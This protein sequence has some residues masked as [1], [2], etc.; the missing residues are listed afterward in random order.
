VIVGAGVVGLACGAALARAG[1]EVLVLE[2]ADRIG[3]Q[4]S[5]R[6][7]EVIHAGIYYPSGSLKAELCR[8]GKAQLY[9]YAKERGIPHRQT[10]KMIVATS[11]DQVSH[12]ERIAGNA[13]ANNVTDLRFLTAR[14]AGALEPMVRCHSALLSPST[15]IIDSHALMLALQG[16]IEADGGMIVCNTP[17]T[18]CVVTDGG[19]L[20]ET[21][22]EQ[23]ARL[24]TRCLVNC[25]GLKAQDFA[26]TIRGLDTAFVPTRH[27]AIGHYY[28][29]QGRSPCDRLIYPVPVDGGLGIHL[30]LDLGGQARFGPD[31][32]WIDDIDYSFDDSLKAE[33]VTAIRNYLPDIQEDQIAPDY[34]GIRPK[35]SGPGEPPADFRID[36]PGFHGI[37]NLVNLFGIESP[38]LTSSLAIG[39]LISDCLARSSNG[40]R[41]CVSGA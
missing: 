10:G 26:H 24:K 5:S 36:G 27:F 31:V 17:V 14:E 4:T 40:A 32:R 11:E 35:I 28:R 9:A 22:G 18:R 34:T 30:T 39:E 29:L 23:S 25:A 8:R 38:G 7:S 33:F 21:G 3:T 2:A 37:A 15:G 1:R 12:L 20:L 13:A 41:V 6:N 19:F 16:D